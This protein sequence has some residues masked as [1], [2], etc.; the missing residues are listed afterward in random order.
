M[1]RL[2]RGPAGAMIAERG[3]LGLPMRALITRAGVDPRAID[4]RIA[5]LLKS[6][7]AVLAGDV[8][9]AHAVLQQLTG[10]IGA[11]L[12][13]HHRAA[14]VA[15]GIPREVLRERACGRGAG[16]IFDR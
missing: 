1:R 8:L 4:E 14:P 13:E 3:A 9:V 15:E 11:T 16:P 10:T 7:E 2:E 12:A 6:S 5:A